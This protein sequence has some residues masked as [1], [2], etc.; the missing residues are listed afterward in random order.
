ML[1]QAQGYA[2]LGFPN[3]TCYD[4]LYRQSRQHVG[5]CLWHSF[6]HQRG[7]HPDPFYGGI[8]DA[9]R[10]PKLSYY[11]FMSQRPNRTNEELIAESGPMVYIANAMTPFSPEDVT[12]YSNCDEVRLTYCKN[13]RQYT[14]KKEAKREGM[15]SPVIT[16]KNVWKVMQDK[17]LSRVGK[18]KDSYLLA[19]GFVE[20]K[21]V[22]THKLEPTRRPSK[23]LLWTDDE[24]VEMQA[25]G[26][27][28]VTV[29][30]AITDRDGRI[31]RLNNSI[32]K[33]EID[34][35]GI[36]IGNEETHTNPRPIQWGT[37]PI[38]VRATT[39]PGNIKVRAFVTWEGTH[40]PIAAELIIPVKE[41]TLKFVANETE[42]R[43]SEQSNKTGQ[44]TVTTGEKSNIRLQN[45]EHQQVQNQIKLKEI[46]K[47]QNILLSL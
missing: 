26:S 27:D 9:F 28:I 8:M 40:T 5:G 24:N 1:K 42:I 10:Q 45:N 2:T 11:M 34:G 20:G 6:D 16:F 3:F 39:K 30:A 35:P 37:A 25:D 22:A 12:I 41:A 23:L 4:I 29:V 38:L 46:E 47:Q 13:G 14:Y 36:F 44:T 7:Y 18:Q 19:E 21:L 43:L 31:K 32:V 33:F 17:A 15:P